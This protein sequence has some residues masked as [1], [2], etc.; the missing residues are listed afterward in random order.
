MG[1][2][3]LI[4]PNIHADMPQ[5]MIYIQESMEEQTQAIIKNP[6]GKKILIDWSVQSEKQEAISKEIML[7]AIKRAVAEYGTNEYKQM[8]KD[9]D[10][11]AEMV[12]NQVAKENQAEKAT[13]TEQASEDTKQ[14][15]QKTSEVHTKE[16]TK[17]EVKKESAAQ[18]KQN[19]GN[20]TE[21]KAG[22]TPN[23]T[24]PGTALNV[25]TKKN[26]VTLK[27]KYFLSTK[28]A[29]YL[30]NYVGGKIQKGGAWV[31][32]SKEEIKKYFLPNDSNI[33]KYKY[34]FLSLE[35]TA[36]ISEKD[37][38]AFLKGKG[39]LNGKEAIFLDAAKQHNINE[40]YLMAHACLETGN[41][42]SQLATGVSYKG[43]IV[44]NMFG[45]GAY[46][47]NA[48]TKGAQYAYNAGWTTP[49][50]AIRGGAKFIS[51]NYINNPIYKQ[52]TLYEMRWNP[53]SPGSHQYATDVAWA[54]KQAV[55]IEQIYK[56]FDDP[57]VIF[58][59]PVYMAG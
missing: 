37:A 15:E 27:T 47:N 17:E 38:G 9:T 54:T 49:E 29:L 48:V 24:K 19:T 2:K 13:N 28:S 5:N 59:I 55:W 30:Q 22:A 10:T 58:D 23:T 8:N 20:T 4:P 31:N 34:Q 56:A 43:T 26:E 35:K 40:I 42:K 33:N 6:A 46:D 1:G 52:D 51:E 41:G 21:S 16:E 45:I 50:K 7:G 53:G 36:G 32:A 12:A 25:K 11:T 18:E 3:K 14:T 57:H 39:I 44:Y